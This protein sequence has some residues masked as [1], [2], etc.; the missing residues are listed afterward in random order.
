MVRFGRLFPVVLL[1]LGAALPARAEARAVCEDLRHE[2]SM[3]ADSIG[4]TRESRRFTST[5]NQLNSDIRHIRS[6]LRRSG[7]SSG[8]IV[9]Y[10]GESDEMCAIMEEELHQAET[11]KREMIQRRMDLDAGMRGEILA[12]MRR[13]GCNDTDPRQQEQAEAPPQDILASR[14]GR[15]ERDGYGVRDFG[16]VDRQPDDMLPLDGRTLDIGPAQ[17]GSFRTLCVRTCDGGFFP[18]S[19]ISTPA[20]FATDAAT[21]AKMCPGTET[22]LY[23]HSM[24]DQE[25]SDMVSAATGAPYTALPAAFAYRNRKDTKNSSC[26]C[27]LNAYYQDALKEKGIVPEAGPQPKNDKSITHIA[28]E[29][30]SGKPPAATNPE[31]G[32]SAKIEIPERSYDPANSRVRQV[33]PQFLSDDSARIDLANPKGGEVQP[34]Q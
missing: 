1:G 24:Q 8:S 25:T 2:L 21:C 23:Y 17:Q 29:S 31:D 16:A 11:A 20:N 6:D 13:N 32:T 33:G 4:S 22:E 34:L 15:L 14:D 30:G 5:V 3:A 26:S 19:S 9:V 27:N 7:C 18:I 28:P 10:G 12:A